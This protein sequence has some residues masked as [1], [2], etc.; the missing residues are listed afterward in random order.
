MN[1][2]E[3]NSKCKEIEHEFGQIDWNQCPATIVGNH[4]LVYVCLQK[5]GHEGK[6]INCNEVEWD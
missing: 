6:H 4:G 1:E 3:L 2:Y 5:I